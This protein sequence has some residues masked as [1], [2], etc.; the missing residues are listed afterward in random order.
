MRTINKVNNFI[1]SKVLVKKKIILYLGGSSYD[2][3]LSIRIS[4][5]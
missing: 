1:Q 5:N 3:I 2:C 4:A